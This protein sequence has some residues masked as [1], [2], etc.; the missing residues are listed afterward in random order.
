MEALDHE[1][2]LESLRPYFQLGM[3][4]TK[5]C[6]TSGVCDDQTILNWIKEDPSISSRI[7]A[8]QNYVSQRAR[9]VIADKINE[10]NDPDAAKWWL[11]R[12]E[13]K[14][15][16]TRSEVTGEDGVPLNPNNEVLKGIGDDL[17]KL[18][19]STHGTTA[20]SERDSEEVV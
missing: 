7:K 4:I 9:T 12:K 10:Q 18:V 2:T 8:W 16:S 19:Q 6:E 15:F 13:K 20:G 17:K 11:E 1:K 3:S 5:A 14:E